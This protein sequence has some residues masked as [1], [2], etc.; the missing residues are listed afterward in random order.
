MGLMHVVAIAI[1]AG[2]TACSRSTQPGLGVKGSTTTVERSSQTTS[3][4]QVWG[5]L[6]SVMHEG[7]TEGNVLLASVVPGPHA[8]AV[9]ALSGLR[10]E[11]TVLDDDVIVSLGGPGEAVRTPAELPAGETATLLV[12][13][14]VP[15][16]TRHVVEHS[17]EQDRVDQELEGVVKSAGLDIGARI[18]VVIEAK[19]K[20]LEWH[21][22]GGPAESGH[23]AHHGPRTVG[24]LVNQTVTLV[25]F[26]SRH[27]EAVFT[28]MGE[29]THFHVVPSGERMTGHVDAMAL[30]PGAIV[31]LPAR[32]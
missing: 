26:F 16:W 28:H 4:V 30:E 17:I 13:A 8:Y 1:A 12:R 22:L 29:H 23:N 15:S 6:R 14:T 5:A 7:K 3:D 31:R 18:P 27:D 2:A 24:K 11:V 10:G 9:G 20:M 21:V 32:R 25:G 19:V